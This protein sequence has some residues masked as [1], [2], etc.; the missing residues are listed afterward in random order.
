MSAL[1][2]TIIPIT[3]AKPRLAELIKTS[4]TEDVVV[5]QRGHATAVIVSID[6]YSDM[7]DRIEDLEDSLAIYELDDNEPARPAEEVFAELGLSG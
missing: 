3:E 6:R 5:T 2:P 4:S 1:M 7:L